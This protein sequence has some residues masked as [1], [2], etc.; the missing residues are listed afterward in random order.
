MRAN[1]KNFALT[2]AAGARDF[3]VQARN[4]RDVIGKP[5]NGVALLFPFMLDV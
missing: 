4:S 2:H 1:Q 5:P 3:E